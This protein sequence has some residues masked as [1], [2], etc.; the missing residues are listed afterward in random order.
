M[1]EIQETLTK[2]GKLDD[3]LKVKTA[4]GNAG[5]AASSLGGGPGGGE[6]EDGWQ[7][8]FDG[9]SLKLWKPAVS[10]RNFPIKDGA[11]FAMRI[12]EEVDYLFFKG[13]PQVPEKL[14]NFELRARV[15]ADPEANSGFYFH[16]HGKAAGRGGHPASGVEVSLQNGAKPAK[17]PTGSLYDLTPIEAAT[18]NQADWFEIHFK[19]T[20]RIVTVTI[21][22]K[23][24]LEHLV[25][26][27][28]GEDQKGIQAEGGLLAIQAN[29]K[30][31]GYYFEKIEI[32]PLP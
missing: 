16:L 27:S 13:S 21:N 29:S 20:G 32:K 9:Q 18:L 26:E 7:V 6:G 31:G 28:T 30:N 19:V 5:K 23:P 14:K 15:R 10:S 22:G 8:I 24:Y 2:E 3:A 11:L 25:A 4:R 12:T 1:A 17:F